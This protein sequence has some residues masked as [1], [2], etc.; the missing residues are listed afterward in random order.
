MPASTGSRQRL[1]RTLL[2]DN[3]DSYTYN[4]LQLLATQACRYG[5]TVREQVVVI[6]NDQYNFTEICQTILPH[7]DNIVISPGPGT[8][9]NPSD[10]GVCQDLIRN[11]RVPVLG[12]CLGHQGIAA[13]FGATIER[14]Q[15]PVHGQ[16]S[17]IDVVVHDH[18]LF[19][20]IPSGFKAVRYHSLVVS[21]CG[22]PDSLEVLARATGTVRAH[23][24][25]RVSTGEIMA[26]GHKTRPLYG[27]QFHPESICTEYGQQLIDN[28]AAITVEALD[29]RVDGRIPDVVRAMSVLA[30][31]EQVWRS[32][33][34]A[35]A[36]QPGPRYVLV[37]EHVDLGGVD[38]GGVDLGRGLFE[39][40]HKSDPMPMWLDSAK[41]DG[42]VGGKLSV[43]ASGTGAATIKYTCGWIGYFGY[44]M[45]DESAY[46]AS[47]LDPSAPKFDSVAEGRMP[48]AQLTF[49]DRCVVLDQSGTC[50]RASVMALARTNEGDGGW[51]GSLGFAT[52]DA[53]AAWVGARVAEI[54]D[55]KRHLGTNYTLHQQRHFEAD[56]PGSLASRG[57]TNIA[58]PLLRPRMPRAEYIRAI[59]EA[60]EYIGQG[61][62]YE[63]CLTTQFTAALGNSE[64]GSFSGAE[65]QE[66]YMSMRGQN[67]APFGALLWYGDAGIAS[68]SPERF[69]RVT[70]ADDECS[71][72]VEMKPIKGTRRRVPVPTGAGDLGAWRLAD[73]ESA[74][75]LQGDV[76][77]R[78]ENLMI[79]DLIRHDLNSVSEEGASVRR[80]M[81]IESFTG[82]HQMV[83]TVE[84]RVR[85][86]A[87]AAL[88]HCFPPGSMT[89]APKLR[90]LQ[91][92]GDLE[93]Q[94]PRGLYSGVLGY[95]SSSGVADFSVVIRSAVVDSSRGV[96]SVG[97]GGAVTAL[98]DA[99]AEWA[100][101]E[102][103]LGSVLP[104]IQQY[105]EK[106]H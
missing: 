52:R 59:K 76:K 85:V 27:V 68:C 66:L 40:L 30:M 4:L 106:H 56:E 38:L 78:A 7:I 5:R 102:T 53:A 99:K 77:E 41:T 86:G 80:L 70:K 62:S 26:L 90:T 43:L 47:S 25:G 18:P 21:D 14:C 55:W 29:Y 22:F 71:S 3:Y 63:I 98:S 57:P 42:A 65:A 100:E 79:V 12:V 49:V 73:E 72:V 9:T 61:E 1:P 13:I 31:D 45:K 39:L 2:V 84:A 75:E 46:S 34:L 6:R 60:Q 28:F 24:G 10:F 11:A 44:E 83:S 33:A 104:A 23:G 20:N 16:L 101:V 35:V 82:V 96:L 94:C 64:R 87:M 17:P 37:S 48:D 15:V 32:R 58:A 92:L 74:R 103:K 36:R 88:A 97:A 105:L 89:G 8:P 54:Q 91:I 93:Q 51:L 81:A 67:P 50:P 95:F 19:H 69:L